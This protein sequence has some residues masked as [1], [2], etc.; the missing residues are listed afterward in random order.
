MIT[1]LLI[2]IFIFSLMLMFCGGGLLEF[3]DQIDIVIIA[4]MVVLTW[5]IAIVLT[6][7]FFFALSIKKAYGW[8]FR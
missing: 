4:L 7:L 1:Y 3:E 2:S 5:P 8:I 6:A